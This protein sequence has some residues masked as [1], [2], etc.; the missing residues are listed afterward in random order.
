MRTE[1]GPKEVAHED[2]EHEDFEGEYLQEHR[3]S[4]KREQRNKRFRIKTKAH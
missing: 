2:D 4:I 3:R 1:G